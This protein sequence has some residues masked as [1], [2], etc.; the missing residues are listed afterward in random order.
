MSILSGCYVYVQQFHLNGNE[1]VLFIA[2]KVK[3]LNI[4]IAAW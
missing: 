1:Y 4:N 2:I 3:Y